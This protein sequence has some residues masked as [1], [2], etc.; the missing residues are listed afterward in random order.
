M[1]DKQL[2]NLSEALA[3]LMVVSI[4]EPVK[5]SKKVKMEN[6]KF[7]GKTIDKLENSNYDTSIAIS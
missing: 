4:G 1:H 7:F 2:L 5:S 3:D 6:S